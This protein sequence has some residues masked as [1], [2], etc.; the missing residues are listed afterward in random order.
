VSAEEYNF[1]FDVS[2]NARLASPAQSGGLAINRL[3]V[4]LSPVA[5]HMAKPLMLIYL[6]YQAYNLLSAKE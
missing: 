6:F 5:L 3:R 1:T 2:V 4:R